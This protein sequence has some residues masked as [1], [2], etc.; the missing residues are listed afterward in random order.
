VVLEDAA[1]CV[2]PACPNRPVLGVEE[3]ALLAG[4]AVPKENFEAPAFPNRPPA[5][6]ADAPVVFEAAP[7]EAGGM[8]ENDMASSLRKSLQGKKISIV[9]SGRW[10]CR[11]TS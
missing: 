7:D 8:K 11:L 4:V 9:A 2:V 10:L 6:G 1:G 3:V 5:A